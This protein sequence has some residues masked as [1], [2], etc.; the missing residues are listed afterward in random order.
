MLRASIQK[1]SPSTISVAFDRSTFTATFS[2]PAKIL[3]GRKSMTMDVSQ[4]QGAGAAQW[5]QATTGASGHSGAPP[6]QKMADLFSRIDTNNSGSISQ[7]QFNQ[8]FDRLSPPKA[9]QTAGK[10]AVWSAL[11]PNNTG[12]VSRGDFT[13]TMKTLMVQLRQEP[14]SSSSS[15]LP[16]PSG[17]ASQDAPNS[18][19]GFYL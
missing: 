3:R 19:D 10:S 6:Q 16:S 8:A 17:S 12:A 7:T 9:F 15:V 14:I 11:D 4:L 2:K 1:D 13:S 18:T 5:S